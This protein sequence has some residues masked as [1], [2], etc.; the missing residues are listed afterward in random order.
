MDLHA[1]IT[2]QVDARE[3]LARS[4]DA[5]DWRHVFD[6]VIVDRDV[7]G[8]QSAPDNAR[9]A[10]V[11]YER[12]YWSTNPAHSPHADHIVSNDPDTVLLRCEADRRIL[13][14]HRIANEGEWGWIRDPAC[15]GCGTYGDCEDPNVDNLNDCPE[16]LDLAHAHGVTPDILAELDRPQAPERKPIDLSRY[17]NG[18]ILTLPITTSDVPEALRGPRWKP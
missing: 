14:R 18:G 13:A 8:W 11:A 4:C 1:W 6:G 7:D 12:I 10:T 16:L 5:T 2:Q 15:Y 9:I 17:A 3:R